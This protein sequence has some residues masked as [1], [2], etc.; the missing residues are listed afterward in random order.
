MRTVVYV[1][2]FNLY[3]RALK[4][5]PYKWLDLF[6]LSKQM[7]R[8][9]N[10][11]TCIRYFTARVKPNPTKPDQHVCQDAYLRAIQ[12][13]IPCLTVHEGHFLT[14][15][16][17]MPLASPTPNGPKTVE[18]IK[19]EE[20]GSD[21]NLAVHLVHDAAQGAFD[22]ALVIS[23]DSD[24]APAITI[25]RSYGRPVGVVNPMT[26]TTRKMNFELHAASS[27]KRRI[28]TK[29]LKAAQMPDAIPD[30]NIRKPAGW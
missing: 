29:H 27:F 7:V 17:R 28:K 8:P 15:R 4:N 3:Y 21:V 5:T 9:E 19:S 10:E 24:L 20:K 11:I 30:T 18:V 12:A 25:A 13:H 26:D 2:G 1:D 23:N 22:V 16:V 6:A 14:S